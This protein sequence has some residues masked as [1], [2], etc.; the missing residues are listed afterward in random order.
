MSPISFVFEKFPVVILRLL[1]LLR[2][3]RLAKSLPRLRSIVEALLSGF[4]AVGW[5]VIFI[6][7]FNYI[8]ACM[9]MLV[10]QRS[11]PFHF[12]SVSRAMFNVLRMETLDSW[13]I[14]LRVSVRGCDNEPG[15]DYIPGLECT[16][17]LALGWLAALLLFGI[18]V[19]GGYVLPTVL[20]GIVAISFDDASR[21]ARTMIGMIE[22]M[23]EV[24]ENAKKDLPA[25]I[26]PNRIDLIRDMFDEMDADAEMTLDFNELYVFFHYVFASIFE[27]EVNREQCEAIFHLMDTDGETD[28][29][30]GEVGYDIKAFNSSIVNAFACSLLLSGLF[31]AECHGHTFCV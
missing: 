26:T 7:I 15:Y 30:Y 25:F 16:H 10:F 3:F 11:D 27:F 5:V 13:D 14:M 21:K 1:R 6:A 24:V 12:G 19:F 2:V 22:E 29:H 4:N 20:I 23:N 28:I 17:P 18:I 9:L 31:D 8:A